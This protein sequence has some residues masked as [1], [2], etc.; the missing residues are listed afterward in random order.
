MIDP[1]QFRDLLVIPTLDSMESVFPGASR[2]EAVHLVIGTA[3]HESLG[4]TYLKQVN[5]PAL[6]VYQIEPDTH[7]DLHRHYMRYQS[8]ERQNFVNG[9]MI[10]NENANLVVNLRYATIICRLLYYR[11]SFEWPPLPEYHP[12]AREDYIR[13]LGRVWKEHFNTIHGAGT[14]EQFVDH[15]PREVL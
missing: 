4:G 5:G 7:M 9:K 8:E 10:P 1:V 13:R 6:G 11:Q 14:V 12:G 2:P 15:F 3:Y